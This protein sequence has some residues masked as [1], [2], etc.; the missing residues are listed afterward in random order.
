MSIIFAFSETSCLKTAEASLLPAQNRKNYSSRLRFQ[1]N[2]S[3]VHR[4]RLYLRNMDS[5]RPPRRSTLVIGPTQAGTSGLRPESS[6]GRDPPYAIV[7]AHFNC[8]ARPPAGE[9]GAL[10]PV[11]ASRLLLRR[12]SDAAAVVAVD[13][14][15]AGAARLLASP[16]RSASRHWLG[17]EQ[18]LYHSSLAGC[19]LYLYL[20]CHCFGD[21]RFS[22][23]VATTSLVSLPPLGFLPRRRHSR[24]F[25]RDSLEGNACVLIGSGSPGSLVSARKKKKK[26]GKGRE[27]K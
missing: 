1:V 22:S 20:L 9:A 27:E 5:S 12:P 7:H 13:G 3:G 2:Y 4:L 24:F 25:D 14:S 16:C 21:L 15:P 17:L 10:S 8:I 6:T 18:L 19:L 26:R 23:P 11:A